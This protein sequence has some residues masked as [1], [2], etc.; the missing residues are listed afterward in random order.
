MLSSNYRLQAIA[1]IGT[2]EYNNQLRDDICTI[3]KV[4]T[5]YCASRIAVISTEKTSNIGTAIVDFKPSTVDDVEK[6]GPKSAAELLARFRQNLVTEKAKTGGTTL[7]STD[8]NTITTFCSS[9]GQFLA[10][11]QLCSTTA[12]KPDD[13]GSSGVAWWIPVIIVII[14]LLIIGLIVG[15][16]L[17]R[18]KKNEKPKQA[19]PIKSSNVDVPPTNAAV[20]DEKPAVEE[21]QQD[22]PQ[23]DYPGV[24]PGL[25]FMYSAP[26]W[27]PDATPDT[28]AAPADVHLDLDH[29]REDS[30][31]GKKSLGVTLPKKAADSDDNSARFSYVPKNE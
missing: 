23:G 15:I 2:N 19:E 20:D 9:N 14:I 8:A 27:E 29:E 12:P 22:A 28:N 4:S 7:G 21:K 17:Y 5:N 10:S 26:D 11:G 13:G 16:C 3:V 6:A 1:Q 30:T 31:K 18:K 25:K 24:Q